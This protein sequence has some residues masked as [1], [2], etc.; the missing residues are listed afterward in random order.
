MANPKPR[1]L[2]QPNGRAVKAR[3]RNHENATV[4]D[5]QEIG[6]AGAKRNGAIYGSKDRGDIGDIPA[7][8][9][10]KAVER[11]Q[12]W[13]HLDEAIDQAVNGGT[14]DELCVVYKRHGAGR[15]SNAW[16]FPGSFAKRLLKSYYGGRDG[17]EREAEHS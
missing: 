2:A 3:G 16:V 6:F 12:M 13:K 4:E 17:A 14:G 11:V 5:W 7:T 1:K 10:C 9:Q 8:C 15:D